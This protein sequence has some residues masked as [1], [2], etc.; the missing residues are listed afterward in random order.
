M[1]RS[2]TF[3]EKRTCLAN[4]MH[5]PAS[6]SRLRGAMK[7]SEEFSKTDVKDQLFGVK[8]VIRTIH[9]VIHSDEIVPFRENL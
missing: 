6:G 3:P 4:A 7:L 5:M 2:F 8:Q 1:H 9:R